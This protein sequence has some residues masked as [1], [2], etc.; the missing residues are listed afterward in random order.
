M[1]EVSLVAGVPYSCYFLQRA[2]NTHIDVGTSRT[3][4]IAIY[5]PT[6][7]SAKTRQ[8]WLQDKP[9]THGSFALDHL[10]CTR[11]FGLL[12]RLSENN[13]WYTNFARA[14]KWCRLVLKG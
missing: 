10:V 14:K 2:K 12:D 13:M 7:T 11:H 6:N 4:K 3:Y 5:C 9:V 1:K 8:N